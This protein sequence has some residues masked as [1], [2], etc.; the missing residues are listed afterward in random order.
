MVPITLAPAGWVTEPASPETA[1]TSLNSTV[2]FSPVAA[3][4]IFRTSPGA[5][6]YCFPPVRMTAY[7]TFLQ[8]SLS[9]GTLF[10]LDD[11]HMDGRIPSDQSCRL[12]SGGSLQTVSHG[13]RAREPE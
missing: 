12:E 2:S 11:W 3:F 5:T 13:G 1:K 4:S 10:N 9:S 8:R 7:I 6:R